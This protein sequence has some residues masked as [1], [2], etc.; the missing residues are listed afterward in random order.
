[1]KDERLL[2]VSRASE[3]LGGIHI[4]TIYRMVSTGEL[5]SIRFGRRVM[6]KRSDL[7]KWINNHRKKFTEGKDSDNKKIMQ[8]NFIG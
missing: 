4:M 3:L 2:S 6:F 1:M 5:P 8:R 7:V